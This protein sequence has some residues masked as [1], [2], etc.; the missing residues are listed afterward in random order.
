MQASNSEAR[1][2]S[3]QARSWGRLLN[4]WAMRYTLV[5]CVSCR[6]GKEVR[7]GQDNEPSTPMNAEEAGL[8]H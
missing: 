5:A 4:G 1:R 8:V 6:R 3:L 7:E 2:Q